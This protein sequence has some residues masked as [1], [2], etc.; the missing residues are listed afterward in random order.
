MNPRCLEITKTPQHKVLRIS[1]QSVSKILETNAWS[2]KLNARTESGKARLGLAISSARA[3]SSRFP[4]VE[5]RSEG[6]PFNNTPGCR[7]DR[8]NSACFSNGANRYAMSFTRASD[9][10]VS[11]DCSPQAQIAA[12]RNDGAGDEI[13]SYGPSHRQLAGCAT[14]ESFRFI[15]GVS[16][17]LMWQE[18]G[19]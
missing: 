17:D 16:P 19:S 2:R 4:S 10:T 1:A 12:A 9:E 13:E 8:T 18:I 11:L 6:S 14:A 7:T 15:G 5:L 3:N